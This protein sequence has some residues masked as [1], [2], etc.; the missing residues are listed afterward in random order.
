MLSIYKFLVEPTLQLFF[1]QTPI[2]PPD[3]YNNPCLDGVLRPDTLSSP[4]HQ[5]GQEAGKNY[6]ENIIKR[7]FLGTP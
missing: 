4:A 3:F 5:G 1:A 2:F 6:D 7:I